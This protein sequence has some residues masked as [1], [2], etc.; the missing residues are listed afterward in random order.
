MV[1]RLIGERLAD[2]QAHRAERAAERAGRGRVVVHLGRLGDRRAA[3]PQEALAVT[4]E[5]PPAGV[6][7]GVAVGVDVEA[8]DVDLDL[9]VEVERTALGQHQH[10]IGPQEERQMALILP[11]GV[12]G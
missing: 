3:A 1:S 9:V 6:E 2:L 7:I 10:V 5:Q 11:I 12:A 8:A 4:A